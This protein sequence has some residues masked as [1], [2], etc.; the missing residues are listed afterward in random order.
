MYEVQEAMWNDLTYYFVIQERDA[1][2]GLHLSLSNH[3]AFSETRQTL[4]FD[5][6]S[7]A[8][9]YFQ[10]EVRKGAR[11]SEQDLEIAR[12][13]LRGEQAMFVYEEKQPD[14]TLLLS[15][16]SDPPARETGIIAFGSRSPRR[17]ARFLLR[18]LGESKHVTAT[19]ET[20]QQAQKLLD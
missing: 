2:G 3:A 18:R 9:L 11:A 6:E 1:E 5:S 14:S 16:H 12:A 10:E 17:L 19:E 15:F 4:P 13:I 20:I 7:D 8:A